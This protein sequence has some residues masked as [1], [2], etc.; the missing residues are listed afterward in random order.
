MAKNYKQYCIKFLLG[1][2]FILNAGKS[3]SQNAVVNIDKKNILIG[4]QINYEIFVQHAAGEKVTV[5]IPDSIPHFEIIE[6]ASIDTTTDGFNIHK[7]KIVFTSF[8][9]GSFS[10]PELEYTVNNINGNTDSFKVEVGYMPIDKKAEPRDIKNIIEVS[11]FNILWIIGG[12]A[13]LLV[14]IISYLIYRYINNKKVNLNGVKKVDSFKIAMEALQK[15]QKE[16]EGANVNVKQYHTNL[17]DVFKDYCSRV[18]Q[19]NF[20]NNTTKEVLAKLNV[21]QINA[22]TAEQ[23]AAALETG[24]STKFAKYHPSF[25]ENEAA[26]NFIKNSITQIEHS[27]TTKN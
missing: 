10:F 20:S 27:R 11:S 2:L 1:I 24:D 3:F 15:L 5:T 22:E 21:Y 12:V 13:L 14:I 17:A 9:S 18:M 26:L 23:T 19:Q 8:D 4:E 7:Q 16:N 25:D 6:K